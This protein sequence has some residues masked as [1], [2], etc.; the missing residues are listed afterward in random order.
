MLP[1]RLLDALKLHQY[2]RDNEPGSAA[3]AGLS[4]QETEMRPGYQNSLIRVE[5]HVLLQCCHTL[6]TDDI[7][8][9]S[10]AIWQLLS[11]ALLI[12]YTFTLV[13]TRPLTV[14]CCGQVA[15]QLRAAGQQ[16]GVSHPS[17]EDALQ[18]GHMLAHAA[19]GLPPQP[20]QLAALPSEPPQTMPPT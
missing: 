9:G 15:A 12:R 19:H 7:C 5:L 20:V 3:F 11:L 16:P 14:L 6:P 8:S 17:E 18:L 13:N 2:S 1:I 10:S 4:D